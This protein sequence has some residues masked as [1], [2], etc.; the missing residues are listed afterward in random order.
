MSYSATIAEINLTRGMFLVALGD[1][2]HMVFSLRSYAVLRE[3]MQLEVPPIKPGTM[4]MMPDTRQRF[5]AAAV[6]GP[7]SLE[8]CRLALSR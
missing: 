5:E 1:G 7:A 4:W 8:D 2:Q 6:A 3:G